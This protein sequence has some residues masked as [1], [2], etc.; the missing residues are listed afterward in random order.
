MKQKKNNKKNKNADERLKIVEEI[1]EYNK[2]AQRVC[3]L[4]SKASMSERII[5]KKEMVAEIKKEENYINSSLSDMYKKL[6]ETEGTR[7]ENEVCL[8]KEVL[9]KFEK[10]PLKMCL[11]IIHL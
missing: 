6:R 8:I 3:L 10:K 9:N 1:L 2:S 11:K 7:Q 4:A 5:L